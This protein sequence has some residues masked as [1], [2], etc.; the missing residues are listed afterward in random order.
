MPKVKNALLRYRIID[1]CI[2]NEFK[3]F[4]TKDNL[5][6]ACE[7]A[8]YGSTHGEHISDST[9]EKDLFAMRME[10]DAPL[11]Y[12]KKQK[13][14]FYGDD[15]F[16]LDDI[17]LNED[18]V[19]A[20]KFAANIFYQFKNVDV[21]EQ[22]EFAIDK[23]LDRV[24]IADKF[25]DK[26][27]DKYVQF[28]TAPSF[29]GSE[30][31]SPILKAIKSRKTLQFTYQKFDGSDS[32]VRRVDPYLLKQ[33]RNR[34]YLIGRSLTKG[35][36]ITFGLDRMNNVESL[37]DKF[38][39]DP[40]FNPDNFFKY[41]IGITAPEGLPDDIIIE[42]NSILA[43]YLISQPIH[44]TQEVI[45]EKKKSVRFK[46]KAF[47]TEELIMQLLSYGSS[48]EVL[49]PKSLVTEMKNRIKEMN[50]LYK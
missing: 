41:S 13:G 20:I 8:L 7:E 44:H 2:R 42:T 17:P 45:K 28:E 30:H 15:K 5:R 34:W 4:P 37:S 23:I 38:D 43:K 35:K 49:E 10:M 21:F 40:N 47:A 36:A 25:T 50:K 27:V 9:I 48:C 46:I 32:K 29:K 18:D 31:L 24:N 26:A 14:Y 22:F 3:P 33:Y 12:S 39:A 16:T 11:K 6:M 19:E 1:K